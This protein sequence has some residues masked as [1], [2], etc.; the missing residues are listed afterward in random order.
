LKK[1][2]A[3][4]L[5]LICSLVMVS[6]FSIIAQIEALS[7]EATMALLGVGILAC[8]FFIKRAIEVQDKEGGN[9]VPSNK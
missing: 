7:D 5:L 3:L 9:Y 1:K 2:I 8:T 4:I 6:H